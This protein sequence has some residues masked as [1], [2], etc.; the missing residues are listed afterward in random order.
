MV[1]INESSEK[2]YLN[3]LKYFSTQINKGGF[4]ATVIIVIQFEKSQFTTETKIRKSCTYP[5]TGSHK[6]FRENIQVKIQGACYLRKKKK[7][8]ALND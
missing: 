5:Q 1:K 8:K 7:K 4:N 2:V 6:K 3:G